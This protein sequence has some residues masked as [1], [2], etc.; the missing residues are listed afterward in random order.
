MKITDVVP[1]KRNK[2]R[3]SVFVDGEYSFSLDSADA[4]RLGVKIDAEITEK[5]I[6]IYNLE[7]NLSKAKEKAF[8]ITARKLV[9]EKE[10]RQKLCDK[11]Y[12]KMICD[13]VIDMMCEY[14]YIDD[15]NYC[16]SF[17]EHAKSK[18][19]GIMKIR[20]ELRKKGVS[21]EILSEALEEFEDSPED[22][23]Y[24]ILERRFDADDLKDFKE[25]QRAVRFFASRGFGFDSINGAISR[26]ISENGEEW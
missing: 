8:D 7:S 21:D 20:S 23:I 22:R 15:Y 2:N 14:N 13:I 6:E 25:K 24:E 18:G 16:T 5:D 11:G 10:L 4:L 26:Y 1:Q 12:D 9:T 3:V 17:F 19:W